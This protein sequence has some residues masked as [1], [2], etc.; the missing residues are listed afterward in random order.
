MFNS[1]SIIIIGLLLSMVS[2]HYPLL[3]DEEHIDPQSDMTQIIVTFSVMV[4]IIAIAFFLAC[5]VR[6]RRC[7][8]QQ[9]LTR[10]DVLQL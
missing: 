10:L 3:D 7:E 4:G 8:L 1:S 9:S 2:A 5:W 6:A